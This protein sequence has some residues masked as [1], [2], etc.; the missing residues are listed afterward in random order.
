M[1]LESVDLFKKLFRSP[2]F[3]FFPYLLLLTDLHIHILFNWPPAE[4]RFNCI[5]FMGGAFS[6][7]IPFQ[8]TSKMVLCTF[9]F[10]IPADTHRI[11]SAS[12]RSSG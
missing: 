4:R 8:T 6:P 2:L 5:L 7:F 10:L 12:M 1:I 11:I 9:G 3:S